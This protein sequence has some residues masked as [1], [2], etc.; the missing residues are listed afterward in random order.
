MFQEF[1]AHQLELERGHRAGPEPGPKGEIYLKDMT[2]SESK[3]TL[4]A[5][6]KGGR[7]PPPAMMQ[8]SLYRRS[9]GFPR[10]NFAESFCH[11]QQEVVPARVCAKKGRLCVGGHRDPQAGE[12][13]TFSPPAAQACWNQSYLVF[14]LTWSRLRREFLVST[15]HTFAASGFQTRIDAFS[16]LKCPRHHAFSPYIEAM[17]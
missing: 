4:P 8:W 9:I 5:L 17:F 7:H 15:S 13:E 14:A 2:P 11:C 16:S 3:L 6:I 12:F 1:D 10:G